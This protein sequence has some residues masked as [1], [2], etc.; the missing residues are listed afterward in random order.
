LLTLPPDTS[1]V[2]EIY[3]NPDDI[4]LVKQ[5]QDVIMIIDA[6]DY[7]EW[8]VIH[9]HIRDISDDF[10]LINNQP[11]FKIKC[12]PDKN[13]LNLKNGIKG[14]LKKGMTFKARCII[15]TSTVAHMLTGRLDRLINP[16]L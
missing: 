12:L 5:G 10:I 11:V 2:G 13:F 8:G 14:Q 1:L 6:F 15:T 9:G 7:R 4:G 16:A 3:I